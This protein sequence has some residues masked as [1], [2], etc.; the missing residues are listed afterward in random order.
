MGYAA[1][2]GTSYGWKQCNGH[3]D[4]KSYDGKNNNDGKGLL[5]MTKVW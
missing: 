1:A 3:Y 5:D 2:N 4:G